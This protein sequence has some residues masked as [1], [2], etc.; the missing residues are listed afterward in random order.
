VFDEI[1]VAELQVEFQEL[2]RTLDWLGIHILIVGLP[3]HE[4]VRKVF[5]QMVRRIRDLLVPETETPRSW[6]L[7]VHM[8]KTGLY[9]RHGHFHGFRLRFDLCHSFTL[10]ILL[11]SLTGV[12]N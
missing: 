2:L 10:L 7:G 6:I 11:S 1:A 3:Y 9:L 4:L 5:D 12:L 8:R